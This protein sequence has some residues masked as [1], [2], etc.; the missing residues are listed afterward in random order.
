MNMY[1]TI[2]GK[3]RYLGLVNIED[4]AFTPEKGEK[5]VAETMRGIEL[6]IVGGPISEEQEDRYRNTCCEDL[7]DGQPKGGEPMLQN[8]SFVRTAT[9]EDEE[10]AQTQ[11]EEEEA[12]L[13]KARELLSQHDLS[14]KLVDVEYLLDRKKLFFYFT[15]EQRVDFRAYVRDLAREFKTRIEL[16]QIG[17]RDEAKTV[18]GLGPCGRECCCGYWLH[19]FDPICIKM[20]KEQNLALNPTKIS[21]V[22]GRLMCCMAYEHQMYGCLW[23][24]LP[25]PGAKIKAPQGVYIILGVDLAHSAF[26]ARTPEGTEVLVSV[27]DF[28][29]FKET[30]MKGENWE[31]SILETPSLLPE[32]G[33]LVAFNHDIEEERLAATVLTDAEAFKPA[34]VQEEDENIKEKKE[35]HRGKEENNARNKKKRKRK[36]KPQSGSGGAEGKKEKNPRN[37]ITRSGEE[38]SRPRNKRP[39]RKKRPEKTDTSKDD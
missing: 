8:I 13:V 16:R 17:V 23:K 4:T 32:E 19:K 25:N 22:C 28:E 33:V 7:C 5:I 14:M 31:S 3:P 18:R 11:R 35:R 6:A 1:L 30:V 34:D 26:R 9:E 27:K 36:K 37:K 12:I 29:N 20:V 10:M 24:D 38:R 21:G 39:L 15:S 2:F